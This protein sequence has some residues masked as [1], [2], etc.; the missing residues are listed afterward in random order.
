MAGLWRV[1]GPCFF[2]FLLNGFFANITPVIC[3]SVMADSVD[4]GEWKSGQRTQGLNSAVYMMGNKAGMALGGAFIGLGL[5]FIDYVPNLPEYPTETLQ[6]I[7]ALFLLVPLGCRIFV[8]VI[9]WFYNLSDDR[10]AEII[11]ELNGKM[12]KSSH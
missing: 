12:E 5:M 6:G 2:I 1:G 7:L 3:A 8:S 4:Y 10:F 11:R 9:M